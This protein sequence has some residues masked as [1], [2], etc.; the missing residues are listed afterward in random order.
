[1]AALE[2]IARLPDGDCSQAPEDAELFAI[3]NAE[4]NGFSLTSNRTLQVRCV[5]LTTQNGERIGTENSDDETKE[6]A[7]EVVVTHRVP[8]SIVS[9]L[10]ALF[11]PDFPHETTLGAMAIAERQQPAA[12]FNIGTQLARLNNDKLLG[13]LLQ[14][15]GL[16]AN[17]LT[18]L[19]ADGL[20]NAAITP[21]GL[22][23]A[24]GVDIGI[25]HLGALTP[26]ELV[27]LADTEIGLLG[28]DELIGLSAELVSDSFLGAN[29]TALQQA[30]AANAQLSD[31][32]LRLFGL[33]GEN[34]LI[35]LTS[36]DEQTV[37][38]ALG[39]AI[40]LGEL[41][42]AGLY[43]G[44]QQ[45][46]LHVPDINIL[47]AA[48]V[49]L[50]IVEPPSIGVGPVGT[51]AYN[52]QVRLYVDV[53]TDNLLGGVL[54][55]LTNTVLGTRIHLPIWI[56]V[57]AG[58]GTLEEINCSA[59]PTTADIRVE[60]NI[61]NMCIGEIPEALR[62]STANSCDAANSETELIRLLH[63]PVLSGKA[64][65]PG[66]TAEELLTG[67]E[68]GETRV[69]EANSLALGDT[70]ENLVSSLL[71]L[72]S[73]LFRA[74]SPALADDLDY[75]Q[76][77]QN[78]LI[79]DLATQYLEATKKANGRYDL[80]K[81][82][83][84]ILTGSSELDDSGN[85]VLPAL[86]DA[87]WP[88]AGAVPS[89]YCLVVCIARWEDGTFS[90]AFRGYADS[91][92]LGLLD[93]F[94]PKAGHQFC[95]GLLGLPELLLW[96]NCLEKNLTSFLQKKPGGINISQSQDGNSIANP[97]TNTVSCSGLLCTLL[98]PVLELL[99]PIL[100]GVGNLLDTVLADVLGLELGRTSVHVQSVSCEAPALV[101]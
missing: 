18:V 17:Y 69:S 80:D 5:M 82:I 12:A 96:N 21:A 89:R 24:L 65:L 42:R 68:P 46:A 32:D 14:G 56:D 4:N 22:L 27:N 45:R 55:W 73:G 85:P 54:S 95:G 84:L 75:S 28:L 10:F 1:M 8:S 6:K 83:D 98:K 26:N 49:E 15:V 30:V 81:V 60:S 50:G 44:T 19:D 87:D 52:A 93:L 70:V 23:E 79:A 90:E 39:S 16:D 88:L 72:L 38:A 43:T 63:M 40:N 35:H 34:A 25:Q 78:Q 9:R 76:A 61:L 74:P 100:N 62:W 29:L 7:V 13:Q 92:L 3:Q 86:V 20:A 48:N 77:A 41:L 37:G 2:A 51:Q 31:V 67:I 11:N 36:D 66:L 71:D 53:D 33:P 94:P 57:V 97:N 47:G 58:K 91:A 99:K 101:Y 59:E 64:N